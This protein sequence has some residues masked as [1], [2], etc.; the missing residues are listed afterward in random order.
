MRTIAVINQKGGVG[1]TTTVANLG[2][3]LAT[4]GRRV[5]LLDLDPQ[6][7]LTLTF[8]TAPPSDQPSIYDILTDGA[9]VDKVVTEV[10]PN[11]WLLPSHINLAAAEMELVSVVGREVLLRDALAKLHGR[12]D[13]L[14]IDCPPSLGLLTINALTAAEEVLIPLQPHFLA[15][16]GVGKLFETV[17]LVRDRLNPALKVSGIL[18]CLYEAGTRL[19]AE[20]VDDLRQFLEK[21]RGT[22]VPWADARIYE[23]VIRRNIKLAE[24]PSHGLTIFDYE[25][26]SHGAVDYSALAQEILQTGAVAAVPEAPPAAE[27][28]ARTRKREARARVVPEPAAAAAPPP[29]SSQE[30]VNLA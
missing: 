13:F 24:C 16:Q 15:L 8:N 26:R 17:A 14:L 6:T 25:P 21:S 30:V 19:A 4:A 2:A 27:P 9:A 11:T 18:L 23:T 3:A 12:Y 7:H 10:R 22:G 28:V 20:V 29:G 5:L 1:K